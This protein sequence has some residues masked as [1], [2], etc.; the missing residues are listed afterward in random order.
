M[1]KIKIRY[2]FIDLPLLL[3]LLATAFFLSLTLATSPAVI[4][5]SWSKSFLMQTPELRRV[6]AALHTNKTFRFPAIIMIGFFRYI[7]VI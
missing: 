7:C 1:Y 2:S 3:S 4:S 5:S 6:K